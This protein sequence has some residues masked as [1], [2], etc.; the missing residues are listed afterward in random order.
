MLNSLQELQA[1]N[2]D[3]SKV[4]NEYYHKW[5]YD[6]SKGELWLDFRI[7]FKTK[8]HIFI[9]YGVHMVFEVKTLEKARIQEQL[10]LNFY[11][12]TIST[13]RGMLAA[14]L[15]G[16]DY[17]HIFL[18]IFHPSEIRELFLSQ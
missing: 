12:I 2:I 15:M 5:G 13:T 3:I 9:D 6:H 1:E 17:S 14:R 4:R 16:S 8:E 18:P 11:G 10:L 7:I